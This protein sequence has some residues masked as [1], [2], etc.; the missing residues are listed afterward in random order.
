MADA[1]GLNMDEIIQKKKI[2][3]N[4]NYP[5]DKEKDSA[6]KYTNFIPNDCKNTKNDEDLCQDTIKS[7]MAER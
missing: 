1:C 4:E 2:N 6:K 3:N 7:N 5:V